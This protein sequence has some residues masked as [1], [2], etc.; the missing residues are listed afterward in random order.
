MPSCIIT[1]SRNLT[2]DIVCKLATASG[3]ECSSAQAAIAAAAPLILSA[4]ADLV[5]QPGG[6]KQLAK[7]VATQ[8]ADILSGFSSSLTASNLT[9]STYMAVR[10][11]DLLASLLGGRAL[12]TAATVA[13]FAGIGER[14]S[15]SLMGVLTPLI[16]GVIG[17][18][19]RATGLN[20]R[21]VARMLIAQKEKIT[22][23]MPSG[24]DRIVEASGLREGIASR[25]TEAPN[26]TGY[27][28]AA[29]LRA[30]AEKNTW[31]AIW[32][33]CVCLLVMVG[34][35]ALILGSH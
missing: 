15:R 12:G 8:P 2:P 7:A 23:A 31:R 4:L 28:A 27:D 21:G 32:P 26:T 20:A 1:L 13:Q 14:S 24:L 22:A 19:Q 17:H 3:L 30:P 10:G 29:M 11:T 25:A 16:I 35:V 6:A 18:E 34:G 33:Y 9:G 5:N